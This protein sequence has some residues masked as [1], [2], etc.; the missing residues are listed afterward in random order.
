MSSIRSSA[1]VGG[2]TYAI[3]NIVVEAKKVEASGQAVR[4]LNIGDPI[5]FGF[6]TPAHLIEAV[7]RAMRDGHNGYTAS[8]GIQSAREAVAD[9]Y[10]CTRHAGHAGPR[11]AHLWD[12]GRHRTGARRAGRRGRRRPRADADVSALHCRARQ[13]RRAGGVLPDRS[14][15]PVAA[16][17]GRHPAEDDT[18]DARA[19]RDRSEQPDRIGV[20]GIDTA[21][22]D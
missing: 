5:P 14:V 11:H 7:S 2:F 18:G 13:A 6:R 15:Q 10:M 20:P 8:A 1:R 16:G 12:V 9:E 4:Y 17:P 21:G 3:R 19:G 22:V